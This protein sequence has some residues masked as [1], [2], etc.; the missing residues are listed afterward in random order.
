MS[1]HKISHENS[2]SCLHLKPDSPEEERILSFGSVERYNLIHKKQLVHHDPTLTQRCCLPI[3]VIS[4]P[5]PAAGLKKGS[6]AGLVL[7]YTGE[8]SGQ[9]RRVGHFWCEM[10]YL[11]TIATVGPNPNLGFSYE[12]PSGDK[13]SLED[14]YTISIV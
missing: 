3:A 2:R 4:K 1:T 6:I 13:Y 5:R 7:E 9:Y 14:G 10:D 11:D 12:W 8:V